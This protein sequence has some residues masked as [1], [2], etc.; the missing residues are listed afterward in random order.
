MNKKLNLFLGILRI[1]MGFI[2]LWA[3]F[4]K[5]LGLGFATC[6]DQKLNLV[7]Y[8]CNSAWLFGGSPTFGFL[9][10]GT[11]GPFALLFQSLAGNYFV[12]ILF[13]FGLLGIGLSLIFGIF[14]KIGTFSGIALLILIYLAGFVPPVNNPIIDEHIIYI[15]VLIVLYLLNSQNYLSLNNLFKK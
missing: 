6:R 11:R 2:F 5:L 14:Y 15:L 4:D 13:M 8:F 3:F 7:N 12:D 10:F 9:K 1:A